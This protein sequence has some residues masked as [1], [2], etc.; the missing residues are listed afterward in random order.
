MIAPFIKGRS[1]SKLTCIMDEGGF[2]VASLI[3]RH[4]FIARCGTKAIPCL[5]KFCPLNRKDFVVG[6]PGDALTYQKTR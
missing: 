2:P 3:T 5:I 6:K 4:V 1:P